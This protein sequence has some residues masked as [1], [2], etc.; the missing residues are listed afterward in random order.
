M[1]GWVN[2][3]YKIPQAIPYI[4]EN[5]F[6]NLG[7]FRWQF[8][9]TK[10]IMLLIYGGGSYLVWLCFQTKNNQSVF[11]Q[12]FFIH[13]FTVI[14][15]TL[16]LLISAPSDLDRKHPYYYYA[17]YVAIGWPIYLSLVAH[18]LRRDKALYSV[19]IFIIAVIALMNSIG[20]TRIGDASRLLGAPS[21]LSTDLKAI[22]HAIQSGQTPVLDDEFKNLRQVDDLKTFP[23]WREGVTPLEEAKYSFPLF[24]YYLIP[25]IQEEKVII[26]EEYR[27]LFKFK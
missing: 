15:I 2:L 17:S 1:F 11:R 3:I 22:H 9:T 23:P 24:Y 12:F 27:E 19:S 14:S 25:Y 16:M 18:T 4:T 20:F 7:F 5:L 21:T 8:L 26:R 13:G 10:P 6:I